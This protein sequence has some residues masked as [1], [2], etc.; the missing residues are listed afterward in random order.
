MGSHFLV[1]DSISEFANES[2]SN[3]FAEDDVI[4]KTNA[5]DA[6]FDMLLIKFLLLF[7]II[8]IIDVEDVV[9]VLELDTG[10]VLVVNA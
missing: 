6:T 10:V 4:P 9:C 5:P 7:V 8:V 3:A 2:K 1:S